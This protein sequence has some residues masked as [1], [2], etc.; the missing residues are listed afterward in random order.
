MVK[1]GVGRFELQIADADGQNAQAALISEGTDHFA[2]LVAGRYAAGLCPFENKKPVIYV[3]S[4]ASASA[5]VVANF[6]GRTRR[7]PGRLTGTG[8][9]WC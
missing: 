7:R 3:H 5:S 2:D 9:R 4:L 1:I 6:K 8:W